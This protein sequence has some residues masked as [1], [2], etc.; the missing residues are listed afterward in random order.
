MSTAANVSH[1]RSVLPAISRVVVGDTTGILG[2]ITPTT[3]GGGLHLEGPDVDGLRDLLTDC[4]Y[5]YAY[6]REW[7]RLTNAELLAH[8]PLRLRFSTHAWA[9]AYDATGDPVDTSVILDGANDEEQR[10]VEP[11]AK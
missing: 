8:L 11:V 3:R 2:T 9:T 4:R 5:D 10:A 6:G 1:S 7:R